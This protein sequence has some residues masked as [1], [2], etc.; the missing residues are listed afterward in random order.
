MLAY[1]IL[2]GSWDFISTILSTLIGVRSNLETMNLKVY[3][4]I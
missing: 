3:G 2:G 1:Y 4:R